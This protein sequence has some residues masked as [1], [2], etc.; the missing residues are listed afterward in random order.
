MV[1]LGDPLFC[2]S[3]YCALIKGIRLVRTQPCSLRQVLFFIVSD[4]R[5]PYIL[6][7]QYKGQQT[8][9]AVTTESAT[10]KGKEPMS[11]LLQV[12]NSKNFI[13][14]QCPTSSRCQSA[15]CNYRVNCISENEIF[16]LR[17][18]KKVILY[19]IF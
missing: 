11:N 19:W 5:I 6:S 4:T 7:A 1:M 2:C 18:E 14:C 17:N 3:L 15:I 12:D 9:E 10:F 8:T 13:S 16:A